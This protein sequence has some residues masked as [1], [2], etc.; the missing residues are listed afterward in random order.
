MARLF[1]QKW[2]ESRAGAGVLLNYLLTITTLALGALLFAG[3]AGP[4]RVTTIDDTER[5]IISVAQ[6]GG[7]PA[8]E[9]RAR[10]HTIN[11]ITLHH[12]GVA[13]PRGKDP[14]AYMQNLQR[15]S[16]DT[17]KWLDLPYH[18]VIDLDGNIY[19]GRNIKFAGDTNT[20]YDPAGHALIEVVGNFEEVEPNEAQLAAVVETMA[21]LAAKYRVPVEK[22]EG[23]KD[24]SRQTVCP[25]KNLYR[26][27]ENGYFRDRVR[28][29]VKAA[30]AS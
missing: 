1:G 4:V 23:H 21:M 19:E 2:L 18:Y 17:R 14:I 7:T 8:D 11:R 30:A 13:F 22:I 9:S 15:W 6:W 24:H 29:R 20:E 10:R 27:L 28:E 5:R 3:C 16:R 25:G 12:A 26:Y